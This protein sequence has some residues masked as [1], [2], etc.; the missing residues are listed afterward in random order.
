MRKFFLMT[1][2]I[3]F[4]APAGFSQT[5]MGRILGTV[6]DPSGAVIPDAHVTITNTATGSVRTLATTGAG[7]YIAPDLLPGPYS[8]GIEAVGFGKFERQGL[9]L[10]VA[11]DI[12][13][14]GLLK[15]GA[16]SETVTVDTQA[17]LI[18]TTTDVLGTTFSNE[19][20]NELPLQGRDFQNLAIL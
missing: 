3:F 13:V 19:A 10:E 4:L 11:R 7:D 15:P 18:N 17:S 1:A 2:I 16:V 14:D 20:I 6:T 5:S 8:V 9:A 12:R